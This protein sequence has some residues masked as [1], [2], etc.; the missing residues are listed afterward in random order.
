M[1]VPGPRLL[2]VVQRQHDLRARMKQ[3]PEAGRILPGLAARG[4]PAEKEG[5]ALVAV[6]VR[7][8]HERR[9]EMVDDLAVGLELGHP[10]PARLGELLLGDL[11]GDV[12]LPVLDVV[13]DRQGLGHR[14]NEVGLTDQPAG[15]LEDSRRRSFGRVAGSRPLVD[16]AHDGV[17]GLRRQAARVGDAMRGL[18]GGSPGRHLSRLDH[19]ADRLRPGAYLGVVD[20]AHRRTHAR[21]LRTARPVALLAVALE[22]RLHVAME[23]HV[24]RCG[25]CRGVRAKSHHENGKHGEGLRSERFP[26]GPEFRTPLHGWLLPLC[27]ILSSARTRR[28]VPDEA[29]STLPKAVG[30]SAATPGP[31]AP[32]GRP[33]TSWRPRRT[34]ARR[35]GR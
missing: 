23:G 17:D 35:A 22:E 33:P 1:P 5:L 8:R 7:R 2:V 21:N 25:G 31:P 27:S 20:E 11:E 18:V 16:P 24:A 19:L 32:G 10:D 12:R 6:L 9:G 26:G 28:H 34:A 3:P 14:Q 4:D 15:V 13:G 29:I 30:C